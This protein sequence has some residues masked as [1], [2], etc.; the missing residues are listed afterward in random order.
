[1]AAQLEEVV[2][3]PYPLDAQDFTPDA[4]QG[5]FQFC[6]WRQVVLTLQLADVYRWQCLAVEFAIGVEGQ[7]LQPQPMQR[8]HV[9]RQFSAQALFDPVQPLAQAEGRLRGHQ[10]ADQ[11]FAIGPF[12]Y[13]DRRITQFWLLVQARFDFPQFDPITANFHLMV[14]APDV[15]QH[16]DSAQRPA[17]CAAG[18]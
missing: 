18:R 13:A 2:V 8:H 5:V 9:V 14:D 10:I 4:R 15:L 6:A 12:L 3:D 1:M 16:P 17:R 7:S 11:V